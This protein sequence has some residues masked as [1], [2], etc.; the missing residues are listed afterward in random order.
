[1]LAGV[2]GFDGELFLP[3]FPVVVGDLDGDGGADGLA[4]SHAGENVDLIGF[5]LHAATAAVSLLAAQEFA[6]DEV[7]VDGEASGEAGDERDECFAVRLAG[8]FETDHDY[9]IVTKAA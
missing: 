8:G 3:V 6:S 4:V 2:A 1:M 7:E 9:L 5:D